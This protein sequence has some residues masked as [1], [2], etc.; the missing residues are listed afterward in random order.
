MKKMMEERIMKLKLKVISLC[1]IAAVLVAAAGALYSCA[2]ARVSAGELS[3]EYES[4]REGEVK[5]AD[6]FTDAAMKFY[7]ELFKSVVA[8]EEKD[9]NVLVSPLS[10]YTALSMTAN[11]ARDKTLSQMEDTLGLDIDKLN[12]SMAAYIEG[13]P[14]SDK[15]KM[16]MANSIWFRE[17]ELT[18]SPDFLQK[19]AD[20]YGA[21]VFSAPFDKSTVKD[22]NKWVKEKTDGMIEDIVDDIPPSVVM[23]LINA[24]AF[25]AEW[26]TIYNKND[27]SEG[28]FTTADGKEQK[29][30]FM[31]GEE[32][33]YLKLDNAEGFIRYYKDR[34][35][36]FAAL[37]PEEGVDIADFIASLDAEALSDSLKNAASELVIASI[38]KFEYDYDTELSKT[39]TSMGIVNA[40][41]PDKADFSGI[42]TTGLGNMFISKVIHKTY[43]A[44]A[45]RGTRAGAATVVEIDTESAPLIEHTVKLD[46]PFVYMIIDT[47]YNLPIFIGSVMEIDD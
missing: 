40:F 45:E 9:E 32:D 22:I 47:Q 26:E 19:N 34:K 46:R 35:Y 17:N 37:L 33:K 8:G 44:V 18:V 13:L 39:L 24:L 20:Y 30:E 31:T 6:G 12:E 38:P 4:K 28:V 41:D 15:Y 2:S 25:D 7:T 21:S 36:A 3:A 27:V 23:Y 42:G 14:S 1:V 29:V 5:V 43:I 11:G 16:S 10:V